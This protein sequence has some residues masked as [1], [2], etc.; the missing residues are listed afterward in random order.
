M[1]CLKSS[2]LFSF[3]ILYIIQMSRPVQ[4][5]MF[6]HTLHPEQ[7]SMYRDCFLMPEAYGNYKKRYSVDADNYIYYCIRNEKNQ[8]S[9]LLRQCGPYGR[10]RIFSSLYEQSTQRNK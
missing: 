7:S 4:H 5:Y 6:E 2:R 10:K 1:A 9:K 3:Y 8:K